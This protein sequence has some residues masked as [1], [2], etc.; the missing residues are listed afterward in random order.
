MTDRVLLLVAEGVIDRVLLLVGVI[1]GVLLLV[2]EGVTDR[3]LLLV[4]VIDG[5]LLLVAE[6][7]TDRVLLLVTVVDEEL[8]TVEV[9][10]CVFDGVFESEFVED[11]LSDPEDECVVLPVKLN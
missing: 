7:V 6:G 3:V 11:E 4:G 9:I 8:L 2:A 1:D 10:D 5:V